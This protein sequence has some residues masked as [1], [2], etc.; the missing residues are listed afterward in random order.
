LDLVAALKP[1]AQSGSGA[2]VAGVLEVDRAISVWLL[3]SVDGSAAV[4][5]DGREL[6]RRDDPRLRGQSWDSIALDLAAGSHTLTFFLRQHGAPWAF[7]ARLLDRATLDVPTELRIRLPGTN[8]SDRARL[9]EQMS[10]LKLSAV[11]G[12][13]SFEP[14]LQ[15]DFPNGMPLPSSS[16]LEVQIEDTN[17]TPVASEK[18]VD[19]NRQRGAIP[20]L[21]RLH[22]IPLEALSVAGPARFYV[23][24]RAGSTELR[25]KLSL[26]RTA[27]EVA[28][29]AIE[30]RRQ[31]QAGRYPNLRAPEAIEATLDQLLEALNR[32]WIATADSRS[33]DSEMLEATRS[34]ESLLTE[35]ASGK[36]PLFDRSGILDFAIPSRLSRRPES[37]RLFV[38]VD[39]KPG[40]RLPLTIALH[41]LN[42]SPKTILDSFFYSPESPGIPKVNGF[43][44]APRAFGNAFYRGA[45]ETS[46]LDLVDWLLAHYPIDPDRVSI[47][48]VSMGGTG[49]AQIALRHPE[50]FA[51]AASLC[52]YQSY[53]IRRDVQGRSIRG[54]ERDLLHHWS[55]SSWAENAQELPFFVAQGTLDLPL[56]NSQSLARRLGQLGYDVKS[57]WPAVGHD[58]WRV[59]YRDAAAWKWLTSFSRPKPTSTVRIKTDALR[60][61]ERQEVKILAFENPGQMAELQARQTS[62]ARI[63]VDSRNVEAFELGGSDRASPE[64][65]EVVIDGV[66]VGFDAKE[67][68]RLIRDARGWRKGPS[69]RY[70]KR[71]GLEGPI[72][73]AFL[74]PLVFSYGTLDPSL[75]RANREVASAFAKSAGG[76]VD[77]PILPDHEIDATVMASHSLVLVGNPR[78]HAL[79]AKMTAK[80][81]I[82]IVSDELR[83][84]KAR[85]KGKELGA[86]FIYPNP[87]APNHY[88]VVIQATDARGIWRALSLPKLLP[89]FIVYDEG[90]GAST[91]QQVLG[92][93]HAR[94]AGFFT[95]QWEIPARICDPLAPIDRCDD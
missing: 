15:I 11:I 16:S 82:R 52:G 79:L 29:R 37:I 57:E 6:W 38:P 95:N 81:P 64:P 74:E 4:W 17:G 69:V 70:A 8:D 77:Y 54:W 34:L 10:D 13:S 80:L 22:P 28:R 72:H 9:S 48:G 59:S 43:V 32:S 58:V 94:A 1:E 47:T 62:R 41:G 84:G 50:R 86:V 63:T 83:L 91:G 2:L 49:S 51:A 53:F 68:R 61:A 85:F 55:T 14:T 90:I 31:V 45:A 92:R 12:A 56:E 39:M 71:P 33:Q 93:G 20:L 46:V 65:L 7:E 66:T 73:D 26:S 36:D 44:A 78:S 23:K 24:V 25:L 27:A 40:Q 88:V 21:T 42:G 87:L 75:L 3:L 30:V 18:I 19:A 35:I 60:Y 67:P 76:D 89:D 5:L